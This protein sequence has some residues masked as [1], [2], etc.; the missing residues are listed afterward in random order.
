[1]SPSSQSAEF[2]CIT[3]DLEACN[4]SLSLQF[5]AHVEASHALPR[6]L[7]IHALAA[8]GLPAQR[9]LRLGSI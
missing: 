7:R 6:R 8:L 2:F 4:L 1:M 3:C 9:N 5:A